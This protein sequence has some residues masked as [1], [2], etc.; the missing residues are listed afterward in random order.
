MPSRNTGT[1]FFFRKG[2]PKYFAIQ[3]CK[4]AQ[5]RVSPI[6]AR[7]DV[8]PSK[9]D[10]TQMIAELSSIGAT[11]LKTN[12]EEISQQ[13]KYV[14]FSVPKHGLEFFVNQILIEKDLDVIHCVSLWEDKY[15]SRIDVYGED[16]EILINYLKKY[17]SDYFFDIPQIF[18]LIIMDKME[19]KLPRDQIEVIACGGNSIVFPRGERAEDFIEEFNT[20][21][22]DYIEKVVH[23]HDATDDQ[24]ISACREIGIKDV[25]YHIKNGVVIMKGFEPSLSMFSATIELKIDR[26]EVKRDIQNSPTLRFNCSP[27]SVSDEERETFTEEVVFGEEAV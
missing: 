17:Y 7:F 4:I 1:K 15:S 22:N 27:V 23:I 3:L 2:I 24:I 20:Y 10:P 26:K 14:K 13:H 5:S 19:C 9:E 11:M 25:Y 18:S 6:T 16:K 8:F 21:F 12:L